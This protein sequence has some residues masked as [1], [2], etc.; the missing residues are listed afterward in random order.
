MFDQP[1]SK[2]TGALVLKTGTRHQFYGFGKRLIDIVLVLAGAP[3]VL[4]LIAILVV[5]VRLDGGRAF[6]LQP[7][8]GK[9]GRIFRLWKL[10]SMVPDAEKALETYLSS[11]PVAR[12]EWDSNQKLRHDPRLTAIGG[13]L[14]RY[15][16]DELP[17]LW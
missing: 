15:S 14:R 12:A 17:Q 11:D 4:P 13:H 7:R 6:Y 5:L 9:D 1:L 16:L 2:E 10:R 8:I 3:L